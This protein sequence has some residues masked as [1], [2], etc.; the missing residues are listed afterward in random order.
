MRL[1]FLLLI[2]LAVSTCGPLSAQRAGGAPRPAQ[3]ARGVPDLPSMASDTGG[4][5]I[6]ADRHNKPLKFSTRTQIVLV[7]V[8]VQD[9]EHHHVAGLKKEDFQIFENGKEQPVAS[10]EEV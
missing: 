6:E 10:V 5:H 9:K 1:R 7:P 2:L 4:V 3:P 8:V